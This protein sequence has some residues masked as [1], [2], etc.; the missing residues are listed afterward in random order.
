MSSEKDAQGVCPVDHSTREAWLKHS[1]KE[2]HEATEAP[3][4]SPVPAPVEEKC[5]VDHNSREVWLQQAKTLPTSNGGESFETPAENC[6]SDR[7]DTTSTPQTIQQI[8]SKTGLSTEREVSTIPRAKNVGGNWVYPSQA[9]FFNAM[10]RKNWDPR[11]DDMEAVVPIHNAVNERAWTEILKWE[12]AFTKERA[13]CPHPNLVKFSG[14]ASK[15]TPKARFNMTFFGFQKPFDRHDWL[16]ER[17]GQEKE[18]IEYV[19]DFY[20]GKPNPLLPDMPSFYLDVRPKLNSFEGCK[21][22][23]LKFIGWN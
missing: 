16:I 19:I 15:I 6:S 9:Q 10:K 18:Q 5:P 22:R 2:Y 1:T 21:M 12:D 4:V 17:C 11:A 3:A 7:L 23:F 8:S 13:Q 20:T 14:D